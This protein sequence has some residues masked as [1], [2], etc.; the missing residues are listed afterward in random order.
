LTYLLLLLSLLS[1]CSLVSPRADTPS[2]GQT[3]SATSSTRAERAQQLV[4]D[5]VTAARRGDSI[6]DLVSARDQV[7]A[8]RA[9]VWSANLARIDWTSLR[10]TVRSREASLSAAR[11][12]VLGPDAWAQA[13]T[14]SWALPGAS[15]TAEEDLWLTFVDEP[16]GGGAPALRL[17]GDTDGPG[18]GSPAPIWWQQPVHLHR[19][20]AALLLTDDDD[21]GWLRQASAAQRAVRKRIGVA[22]RDPDGALV[23][24][25]PQSRTAFERTLGVPSSSY[26]GVAAAAWPMGADTSTAPIHVIVNP[27][28]TARLSDLGRDVLLTH[29]AVHVATR[30]PGSP[31]PTWLV[32]GYA[33]R[34]AYRAHPTADAPATKAVRDAVR[35][36]GVPT[37][38]PDETDFAPGATDLDL[39][40]DLAWTA[41]RSIAMAYGDDAL[42]AFYAAVDGGASLDEAADKIGTTQKQLR[43]R[44]R[45]DLGELAAR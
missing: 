11:R 39:S 30:S 7:F 32:E 17:A 45:T 4:D 22:E 38:W 43:E 13:V 20:G 29:E 37:D 44:W 18:A 34:I 6:V 42:N 2:S 3:P 33:D 14:V 27:E 35:A 8:A 9:A 5:I 40:Y 19:D 23:V 1:G 15:R 36:D 24:E 25:I 10:W 12:A 16:A 26:A 31:A 21:A 28:A 41:A